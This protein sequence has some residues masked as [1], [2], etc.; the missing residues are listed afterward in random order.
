MSSELEAIVEQKSREEWA[1]NSE[2]IRKDVT[3]G[4]ESSEPDDTVPPIVD[5]ADDEPVEE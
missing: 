5:F 4:A 3:A 2:A 1:Q